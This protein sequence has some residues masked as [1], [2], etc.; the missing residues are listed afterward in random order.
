MDL[1][2]K[3]WKGRSR[4]WELP[5]E[6]Q[7]HHV[8]SI[9]TAQ[10]KPLFE[11]CR[12]ESKWKPRKIRKFDFGSF[13]ETRWGRFQLFLTE[14]WSSALER[15][16]V[17]LSFLSLGGFWDPNLTSWRPFTFRLRFFLWI[18]ISVFFAVFICF[19]DRIVEIVVFHWFEAWTGHD[20]SGT[21][22]G[23][24]NS[25]IFLFNFWSKDPPCSLRHLPYLLMIK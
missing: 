2:I 10:G 15:P 18:S 1:W 9:R 21:Q 20:G 11:R 16:C 12:R 13:F 4:S 6:F 22:R 25:S 7:I 24:P 8:Q 19:L 3:N 23:A 17:W 5:F 14:E